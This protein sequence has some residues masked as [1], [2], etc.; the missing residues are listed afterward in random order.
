MGNNGEK[1]PSMLELQGD[2]WMLAKGWEMG[3]RSAQERMNLPTAWLL[4]RVH[5]QGGGEFKE[6]K[7]LK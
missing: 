5:E 7:M 3:Q 2:H 4:A 1:L 6:V